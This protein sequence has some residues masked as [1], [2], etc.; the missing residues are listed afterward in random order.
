MKTQ[1][2]SVIKATTF[3]KRNIKISSAKNN[4]NK[5]HTIQAKYAARVGKNYKLY[6]HA[7]ILAII[8]ARGKQI[9]K[10]KI[11]RYRADGTPGNAKPCKI[12]ELAIKEAKIKFVEYTCP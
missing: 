3:D 8:R 7:E 10:I 6:L 5:T 12:C 9:H 11:E 2:N 1:K 4:Y